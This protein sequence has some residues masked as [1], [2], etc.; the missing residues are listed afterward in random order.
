MVG[1]LPRLVA[2]IAVLLLA[3]C[4]SSVQ[5]YGDLSMGASSRYPGISCAPFARELSGIALYG[6]ADDWWA[7]AGGRYTRSPRPIL[8]SVLV[9]SRQ[10]RLPSGHVSV[11]SRIVADRQVQVTQ[12]NWVPGQLDEDQLVLDV[13]ARNDWTLVR[14]WYPPVAQLGAHSYAAYGFIHPARPATRDDMARATAAAARY[15]LDT[16]GRP[17]PRARGG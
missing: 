4:G 9:F 1:I 12:A 6:E 15:G 14:V 2:L 10:D 8:G 5:R 11:V 16:R 7:D 17:A 13:S 3:A